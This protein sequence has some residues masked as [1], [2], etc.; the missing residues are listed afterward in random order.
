MT[1]QTAGP[2]KTSPKLYQDFLVFDPVRGKPNVLADITPHHGDG[3]QLAPPIGSCRHDYITKASQSVLPPLD[4]RPDGNTTYKAA[5]VCKK[6]RIHA[7]I[8]LD[9]SNA[10]TPCPT[11]DYPLHHFQRKESHD[12]VTT[13]RIRY[14]WQCS[15]VECRASLF[16]LFRKPRISDGEKDLLT[17]P[18]LLKRRYN[19]LVQ[20]DPNREGMKEATQMDSL[21]RL[22]RYIKDSLDPKRDRRSFPANNKRFQEAFGINGQDCR[23]LLDRLGFKYAVSSTQDDQDQDWDLCGR[24]DVNWNLPHPEQIGDRL[25]ADGKS[26]RELLEDVEIELL[27]WM[28]KFSAE[29]GL[30]NPV[31]GEHITQADRDIERTLAAQGCKFHCMALVPVLAN[32]SH[33]DPRY[34]ALRRAAGSNAD[35]P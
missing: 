20:N 16:I 15:S 14:A 4:L 32:A 3:P 8:W 28:Q 30:I 25:T 13:E 34:V 2:G 17:N 23:E 27:I 24:Q 9:H 12:K 33:A 5:V 35:L 26:L 19:A 18:E 1:F 11:S 6:C 7:D 22:R 29:L 10:K 21:A 31:S